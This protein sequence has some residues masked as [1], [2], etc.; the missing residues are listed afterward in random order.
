MSRLQNIIQF[1]ENHCDCP[2]RV[3]THEHLIHYV[4]L[5]GETCGSVPRLTGIQHGKGYREEW[6]LPLD[7]VA[8]IRKIS[9][10]KYRE[11]SGWQGAFLRDTSLVSFNHLFAKGAT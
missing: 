4:W 7:Q 3:D 9:V 8:Q 11:L 5:T 6:R 1:L 10:E 2:V